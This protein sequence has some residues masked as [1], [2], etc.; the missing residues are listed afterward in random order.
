MEAPPSSWNGWSNSRSAQVKDP[1]PH[2]PLTSLPDLQRKPCWVSPAHGSVPILKKKLKIYCGCSAA[3]GGG[4][5]GSLTFFSFL[6]TL[7][8]WQ[9][10]RFNTQ[11]PSFL[12][13]SR[14]VFH[15]G[16]WIQ[17]LPPGIVVGGVG[18]CCFK[19]DLMCFTCP[20]I[21]SSSPGSTFPP[22]RVLST[23]D[24][25]VEVSVDI[26]RINPKLKPLSFVCCHHL[27]N[28]RAHLFSRKK[29]MGW[30]KAPG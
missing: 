22:K 26:R 27:L 4:I 6:G 11:V 5:S 14:W 19:Q 8:A 10:I 1:I 21:F 12:W 23:E 3:V 7:S 16:P 2:I 20:W 17:L 24:G 13:N 28:F 25:I 9:G 18:L 30:E 29:G 15:A